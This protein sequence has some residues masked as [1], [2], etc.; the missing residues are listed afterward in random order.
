MFHKKPEA[1]L[2]TK[3]SSL[4]VPK[5]A[6]VTYMIL[7]TLCCATLVRLMFHKLTSG[8][9]VELK[10]MLSSSLSVP[11]LAI[12]MDMILVTVCCAT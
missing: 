4:S 3:S 10:L 5:L 9:F 11:K 1:T 12:G 8:W 2:L 7:V 6:I